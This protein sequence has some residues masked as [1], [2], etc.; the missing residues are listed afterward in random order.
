[1]QAN[2]YVARHGQDGD[3]AAGI[4]NGRR[5]SR[6]T[7]LGREQAR[8]LAEGIVAQK[9]LPVHIY[10]SPLRRAQSTAAIVQQRLYAAQGVYIPLRVDDRLI[11]RDFG[12]MTGEFARDIEKLCA[13]DII[14][15]E[16]TTFFLQPEHGETF[17]KVL[18]RAKRF[19]GFVRRAHSEGD[20]LFAT[21][22]DIGLMLYAAYYE[23][24]WEETLR[25]FHFGNCDLLVL[26]PDSGAEDSHLIRI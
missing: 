6:L 14:K 2:I 1:M 23:L 13:P 9:I 11:E 25:R 7:D 16:R 24:E 26:S 18:A 15:T 5:D 4:L 3:N 12:M 19:L 10:S 17:P 20:L 21:H 22:G 8:A